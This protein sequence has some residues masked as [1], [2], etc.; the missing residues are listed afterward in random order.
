MGAHGNDA[1]AL[2]AVLGEG[3]L[4]LAELLLAWREGK[5]A[6]GIA[7][8]ARIKDGK[9]VLGPAREP[10]NLAKSIS[11]YLNGFYSPS[12]L[13]TNLL[14]METS[15][16]CSNNCAWCSWP[17]GGRI[18]PFPLERVEREIARVCELEDIRGIVFADSNIFYSSKRARRILH[19]IHRHDPG[20]K[21]RW[22]IMPYLGHITPEVSKLCNHSQ[23]ELAC[24]VETTNP[25]ALRLNHRF[26]DC[27]AEAHG[28]GLLAKYASR[29]FVSAQLICGLP[30]DN[31]AGFCNSVDDMFRIGFR[32]IDAFPMQVLP[33]T[34]VYRNAKQLGLKFMSESPFHLLESPDFPARDIRR[35]HRIFHTVEILLRDDRCRA[36]LLAHCLAGG[37]ATKGSMA[38]STELS[39]D[40]FDIAPLLPSRRSSL[41]LMTLSNTLPLNSK[42]PENIAA[43]L[44]RWEKKLLRGPQPIIA[45]WH[46]L[47]PSLIRN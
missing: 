27:L 14:A 16:G 6:D 22:V 7:G 28:A 33:G 34:E 8:T 46:H 30:G 43:A 10:L 32:F 38:L 42:L 24:G 12:N 44:L 5:T 4:T 25:V 20:E 21:R 36:Q 41:Q 13:T 17:H 2:Y 45:D 39:R 9:L 23:I 31:L 26:Y 37:S 19:A 15:R 29:A 35:A 40:G 3:E 11:P 47:K 1:P 18:R